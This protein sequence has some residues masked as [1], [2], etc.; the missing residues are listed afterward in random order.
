MQQITRSQF[1]LLTL[2][3]CCEFN[4]H[5]PHDADTMQVLIW[6]PISSWFQI[7]A[8]KVQPRL[9]SVL[10]PTVATAWEGHKTE[11]TLKLLFELNLCITLL[12]TSMQFAFSNNWTAL[13]CAQ[14]SGCHTYVVT[15]AIA[16]IDIV[17]FLLTFDIQPMQQNVT[18]IIFDCTTLLFTRLVIISHLHLLF[19]RSALMGWGVKIHA[20]LPLISTSQWSKFS[21]FYDKI[22][23]IINN[24]C[25]AF[26]IGLG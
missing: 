25:L 26:I 8:P 1:H 23:N 21:V 17:S 7:D 18:M 19:S 22:R 12:Q 20:L 2:G 9:R 11:S 4:I 6:V 10:E 14:C 3:T 5:T 16:I 15:T 24:F 13:L